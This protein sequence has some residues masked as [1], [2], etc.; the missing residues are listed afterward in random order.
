MKKLIFLLL[1]IMMSACNQSFLDVKTDR[2]LVVPHKISDYQAMMDD[3]VGAMNTNASHQLGMFAADECFIDDVALSNPAL[4]HQRHA[5]TWERTDFYAGAEQSRD[6]NMAY[7]RIMYCNIVLEGVQ[8]ISR[9][10]DPLAWDN[11]KGTALF[12]RALSLYQLAQLFCPVYT[13]DGA[14]NALGLPLRKES[15]ITVSVPRSSLA[16]TYT[17]ILDDLKAAES[18]L[19]E[20]ALVPMRPARPALYALLARI[21]LQMGDYGQAKVYGAACLEY[22]YKLYDF[23]NLDENKVTDVTF[24]FVAYNHPEVLFFSL[25]G[26]PEINL[27]AGWR[28]NQETY[29]IYE[30]TDIRKKVFFREVNGHHRFIGNYSG[31]WL[32]FVGLAIDEVILI[33]A[34]TECRIGDEQLALNWLNTLRKNR[35]RSNAYLPMVLTDRDELLTA[36]LLE[37]RKELLL[38]GVRWD[39]MRRLNREDRYPVTLNRKALG[40]EIRVEPNDGRYVFPLSQ[41]VIDLGGIEQ[42]F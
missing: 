8:E 13:I 6:W 38:R 20:K 21:Y 4:L 26:S 42:N 24:D 41:N 25:V 16:E 1:T 27:A 29:V 22:P 23:N 12:H 19:P 32:L 37:R 17:F 33:M 14:A 28:V 34:E 11:V 10:N 5:Y 31:L 40:N 2:S 7:R 9:D 3:A 35:I 15:D 39:D 36:I 18:L 30:E